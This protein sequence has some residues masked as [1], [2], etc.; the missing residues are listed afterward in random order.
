M[1]FPRSLAIRFHRA[2]ALR[3]TVAVACAATRYRLDHGD[4]PA[5]S[6]LLVPQYLETMPLD[7]FDGQP[8]RL[9]KLPDGGLRIYSV[10]TN[11]KDNGGNVDGTDAKHPI[12]TTDKG[13]ILKLPAP[14]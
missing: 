5:T 12:D 9:K 14:R 8:L 6:N 1:A 7:P 11:G 4:Y 10:S 2:E 3:S 13:L